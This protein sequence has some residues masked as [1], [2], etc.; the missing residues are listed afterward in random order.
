[1]SFTF[2]SGRIVAN[3]RVQGVGGR[4]V[5]G[6]FELSINIEL[7]TSQNQKPTDA[8]LM[9][10]WMAAVNCGRQG[11]GLKLLGRA[12]PQM[13][14]S[15]QTYDFANTSYVTLVLELTS[16]KLASLEEERAGGDLALQLQVFA[17][18]RGLV[19]M[20]S[21][22]TGA[23]GFYEYREQPVPVSDML[24]H[25]VRLTEWIQVLE[26]ME[27]QRVMVFTLGIPFRPET[28]HFGAA[29]AMLTRARDQLSQGNFDVVVS[30]AR[31]ILDS[32]VASSGERD[33]IRDATGK[34]RDGRD[35][36]ESMTKQERALLVQDAIR[37]YTHLAHHVDEESGTPE[38]YS[39]GDAVFVLTLATAAF[40][41]AVARDTQ[42]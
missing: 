5:L 37:H 28:E 14:A 13:P 22:G 23:G 12:W 4:R 11:A 24:N 36:R 31:K 3:G 29:H 38:W 42:E 39:R 20:L 7:S 32:L 16:E 8:V 26:Q 19:Q 6:G 21:A 1:M 15:V 25:T 40:S 34:F 9:T 35:S 2:N 27:Y 41:E 33:L 10:D 30:L 18:G 17:T